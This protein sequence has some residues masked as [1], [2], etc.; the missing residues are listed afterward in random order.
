MV[1]HETITEG[2]ERK[3]VDNENVTHSVRRLRGGRPEGGVEPNA[4]MRIQLVTILKHLQRPG[5]H[6]NDTPGSGTALSVGE[7]WMIE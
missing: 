1:Q 6:L 4:V 5:S 3:R 7:K 2:R